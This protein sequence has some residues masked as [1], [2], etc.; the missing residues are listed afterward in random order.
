MTS[1]TRAVWPL[2]LRIF[3][4]VPGAGAGNSTVAFSDSMVTTF[5]S[6]ATASASVMDSPTLGT[7]ISMGIV[8]LWFGPGARISA[9]ERGGQQLLLLQFMAS[10]RPC[11]RTRGL[12]A[13]DDQERE[14]AENFVAKLRPEEAAGAHVH[15]FFLD[16]GEGRGVGQ[17]LQHGLQWLERQRVEL[18]EPHDSHVLALEFPSSGFDFV[19]DLTGAE[20]H[21]PGLLEGT[22]AGDDSLIA[23]RAAVF[24]ARSCRRM[25]QQAL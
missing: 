5:S 1:P 23:G 22:P 7:L 8:V 10:G 17:R 2:D 16:P 20:Q 11:G 24:Q 21:P 14:S 25:P 4:S 13:T 19:E 15:G 9:G 18:F 3:A 6:R 12:R